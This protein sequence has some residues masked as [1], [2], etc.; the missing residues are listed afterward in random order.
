MGDSGS[1]Q[2][3]ATYV[4][5]WLHYDTLSSSLYKQANRARQVRDEFE[6]K[7]I[8]DLHAR[9]MENA[10][11]QINSGLLRVVEERSPRTL[12]IARIDELLQMYFQRKGPGAKDESKDIMNFIRT[13]RG[14]DTS[15]RL[16]KSGGVSAPPLPPPPP[17]SG[18]GIGF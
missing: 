6:A 18:P 12:T 4:R 16:R 9:H 17:P 1:N 8:D 15:K 11:I 14:Y 3:V 5:S 13:H 2:T 7:V 10:V